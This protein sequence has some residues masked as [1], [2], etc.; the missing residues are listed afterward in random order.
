MGSSDM[1][2]Y[3]FCRADISINQSIEFTVR[4]REPDV[5]H[6]TSWHFRLLILSNLRAV[7]QSLIDPFVRRTTAVCKLLAMFP[8]AMC[9]FGIEE[10][11]Q[12]LAEFRDATAMVRN[13]C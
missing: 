3:L 6:R 7:M 13:D 8:A 2:L 11:W 12:V 5:A 4:G 10:S 9:R 1:T